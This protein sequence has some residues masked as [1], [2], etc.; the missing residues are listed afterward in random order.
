MAGRTYRVLGDRHRSYWQSGHAF[1]ESREHG[2]QEVLY[3]HFMGL[4]RSYHWV[5][6]D[7]TRAYGEFSFSAA[8]FVPWISP[9]DQWSRLKTVVRA[10]AHQALSS[11]R[12]GFARVLPELRCHAKEILRRRT[13][14]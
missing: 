7:P 10:G 8:G 13:G 4:K 1:I 2:P 5:D 11:A 6:Y 12:G 3:L 14:Q 9:P